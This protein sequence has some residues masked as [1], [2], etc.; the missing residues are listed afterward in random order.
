MRKI[1]LVIAT[2]AL[3]KL[4][5][6]FAQND[7]TRYINGLPVSEDDTAAHIQQRDVQPAKRE[8]AVAA[9]DLPAQ[10]REALDSGETYQGWRDT[11]IYFQRNTGLYILPLRTRES[12]RIFGLTE[13]GKPV[14][15]SEV[16]RKEER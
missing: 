14:T 8:V 5:P 2:F 9:K 10:L 7:S 13:S 3:L 6:V 16:T 1:C 11:T 4:T 15:F 12:I